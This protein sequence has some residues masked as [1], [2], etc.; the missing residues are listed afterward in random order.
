MEIKENDLHNAEDER[1]LVVLKQWE[2]LIEE[3]AATFGKR[4]NVAA[5]QKALMLSAGFVQVDEQTF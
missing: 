5:E 4:I 3:V 1:L 2:A